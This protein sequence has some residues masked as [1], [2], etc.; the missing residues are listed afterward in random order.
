MKNITKLIVTALFVV[1]AL[2]LSGCGGGDSATATTG[3]TDT[4]LMVAAESSPASFTL[5][6]VIPQDQLLVDN[7]VVKEGEEVDL[8]I[9]V[10]TT[11]P[12]KGYQ[13]AMGYDPKV[14]QH[15]GGSA[16]VGFNFNGIVLVDITEN[17]PWLASN[18]IVKR[19]VEKGHNTT[20]LSGLSTSRYCDYV[21]LTS[22]RIKGVAKGTTSVTLEPWADPEFFG[23][24]IPTRVETRKNLPPV[25]FTVTVN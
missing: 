11:F 17:K 4:A 6:E 25:T 3:T 19:N 9:A 7:Y 18:P 20:L 10:N 21:I 22:V 1:M 14:I 8:V 15:V 24:D 12:F 23:F 2:N 13:I 16:V 5:A